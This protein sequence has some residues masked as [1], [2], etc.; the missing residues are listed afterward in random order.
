MLPLS[1]LFQDSLVVSS[2]PPL[3]PYNLVPHQGQ[4]W[5]GV[6]DIFSLDSWGYPELPEARAPSN[7]T[8]KLAGTSSARPEELRT[9]QPGS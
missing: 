3:F 4:P 7:A 6:E 5:V 2:P 1:C 9:T 8:G